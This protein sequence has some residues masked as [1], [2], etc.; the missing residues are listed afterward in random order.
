MGKKSVAWTD[1]A[2]ANLRAIDRTT[3]MRV[4]NTIARYLTTGEGGV[5][6]LQNT[7]P[8]TLCASC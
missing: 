5:K 2:K 1:Q 4:L 8:L 6:R 3:T 7:E